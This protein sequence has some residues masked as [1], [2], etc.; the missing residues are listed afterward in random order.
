MKRYKA[1]KAEWI[2]LNEQLIERDGY[3]CKMCDINYNLERHH[4]LKTQHGGGDVLENLIFLCNNC[5]V[6]VHNNIKKSQELGYLK[7]GLQEYYKNN[8]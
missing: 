6:W 4:I 5:H 1:T 7:S 8:E 3:K 2:I